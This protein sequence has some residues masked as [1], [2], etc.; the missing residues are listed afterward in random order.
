MTMPKREADQ[1]RVERLHRVRPDRRRALDQSVSMIW[2]GRGSTMSLTLKA[3]QSTSH[4]DEEA[5]DE[6]G[7]G[8]AAA[9]LRV[10]GRGLLGGLALHDQFAQ[11]L[12]HAR[13]IPGRRTSSMVRGR[14]NGTT[15]S[16]MMRPGRACITQMRL[17]R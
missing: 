13:R 17:A 7:R 11:A 4:S 3:R 15:L 10:H 2:L 16:S 12:G 5:D 8:D 6:G 1:R 9:Q 14:G